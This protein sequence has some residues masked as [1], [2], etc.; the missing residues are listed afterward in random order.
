M[1]AEIIEVPWSWDHPLVQEILM[2]YYKD[3]LFNTPEI[4][5][6]M[7]DEI[8]AIAPVKPPSRILDIGCGL[9]YHAVAFAKRGF[10]VTAFDPGDRY[11]EKAKE[12]MADSDVAVDF[13]KMS[14]DDLSEEKMFSL[15]WA[16]WYCPGHLGERELLETFIRVGNSLEPGGWFVSNVAGKPKVPPFEKVR[17]WRELSDCFA[18]S[19]KWADETHF[20]ENSSFVYPAENRVVKIV[21]SGRMYG[22]NEIVPLL[23]EAGF[24]DVETADT[25]AGGG[26]AKEGKYFAFW[27]RRPG[28]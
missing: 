21:E 13:R 17:G 7:L 4:A 11:I 6:R 26:P 5:E 8:L 16:G 19:E 10:G 27:C 24:V 25:L 20:H 23:K 3:W 12:H 14:S 28:D 2:K 22:V 9:G 15:A 1:D 18:L